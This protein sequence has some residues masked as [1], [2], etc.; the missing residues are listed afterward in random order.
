[1]VI[2]GSS[3]GNGST[4]D[5]GAGTA[6]VASRLNHDILPVR[7]DVSGE[8][9]TLFVQNDVAQNSKILLG[10]FGRQIQFQ[11]ILPPLSFCARSTSYF[12]LQRTLDQKK[13]LQ[14]NFTQLIAVKYIHS[15]VVVLY[16]RPNMNHAP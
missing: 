7:H 2:V 5:I 14:V 13:C 15:L 16:V 11:P 12:L 3:S 9:E 10:F 6:R 8:R 4:H 1:M